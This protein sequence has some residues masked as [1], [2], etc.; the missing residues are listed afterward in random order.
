[1]IRSM[2]TLQK[3][4]TAV[5]I[6]SLA[7]IICVGFF[8]VRN[9]MAISELQTRLKTSEIAMFQGEEAVVGSSFPAEPLGLRLLD[10]TVRSARDAGLEIASVRSSP[11]NPEQLGRNVY[12]TTRVSI[13]VFGDVN[14]IVK[15]MD[16]ME[17]AAASS[18]AIDD[19]D[20]KWADNHWDVSLDVLAYT[21]AS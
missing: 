1:M 2:S 16:L 4:L 9:Q 8:W 20:V 12:Q 3:T 5:T 11:V 15:F 7:I 18:M 19:I 10:L 13:H 21:V 17:L 14:Q 6:A